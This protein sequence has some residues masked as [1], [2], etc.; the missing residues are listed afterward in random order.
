MLIRQRDALLHR[1]PHLEPQP[2]EEHDVAVG[3]LGPDDELP[4]A[5][6]A[7][8]AADVLDV[9]AI[10]DDLELRMT[11]RHCGVQH[12]QLAV[13]LPA[14]E[15]LAGRQRQGHRE[16]PV[17][18]HQLEHVVCAGNPRAAVPG[19]LDSPSDPSPDC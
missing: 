16:C 19:R 11:P 9:A 1:L 13:G 3:E 6:G 10:V 2:T 4:V 8:S 18:V 5:V 12:D 17:H 15:R 7:Q 14:D